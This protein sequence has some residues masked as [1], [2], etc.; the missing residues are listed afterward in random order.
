VSTLTVPQ[1]YQLVRTNTTLSHE[2]ACTAVAI[3]LAE[4]GLRTDAVGDV[5]LQDGTWG[6]SIGLW[7]VRS[8]KAENGRGTSRDATR[9]KDPTFNARSMRTISGDG[10]NFNPWSTY[11]N[12]AYRTHLDRVH[13]E[14]R[15]DPGAAPVAP[16]PSGGALF[17]GSAGPLTATPLDGSSAIGLPGV[18]TITKTLLEG[19]VIAAGVGL[20]VTLIAVG[21]WR[22]VSK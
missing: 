22:A 6:P 12:G 8:I 20:G 9:L 19:L 18:D 10:A 4:S 3:A 16:S 7:Q 17:P 15:Q 1:A 11:K 5:G 21:A 13:R 2:R 14:A